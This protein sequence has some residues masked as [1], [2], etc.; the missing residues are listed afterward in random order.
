M[1]S[2]E[3]VVHVRYISILA[4]VVKDSS[5]SATTGEPKLGLVEC[6]TVFYC[7]KHHVFFPFLMTDAFSIAIINCDYIVI[8]VIIEVN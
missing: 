6:S 3:L 8:N 2:V 7:T 5:A 1:V 4:C